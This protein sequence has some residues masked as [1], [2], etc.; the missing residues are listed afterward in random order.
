VSA[1]DRYREL[2]PLFA[3]DALDGDEALE[4]RRHLAT[5]AACRAE[6]AVFE[7][8]AAGIGASVTP[9]PPPP[10]LRRRVLAAVG[11]PLA[12]PSLARRPPAFPWLGALATAAALVLGLGLLATRDELRRER[13]R[14]QALAAEAER[15]R[16]QV[17]D[18]QQALAEARS[19][20]DLVVGPDSQLTLL[21]GLPAAPGAR[22]RMF[23][24]A[25]TRE[26]VLIASGLPEPPPGKAYEVWVIG[27]SK[28]PAPAGVFK[29]ATDGTALVHLPRVEE[30]ARPHTFA[31][32]LE[33]A[34]GRPS[35]T[36]PMVLAGAVS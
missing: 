9:V 7:R 22:A 10:G 11:A 1:E 25:S 8:A 17:A 4:F 12:P 2:V 27:P 3:L 23:W 18:L 34:E 14:A 24:N 33:P 5:C 30:T 31:V 19:V 36:G 16:Q 35:P 32:T 28:Q 26:A 20:R 21:A 6:L 29:P 15:A 13:A